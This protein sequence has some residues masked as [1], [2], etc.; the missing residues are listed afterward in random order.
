[1]N[2]TFTHCRLYNCYNTAYEF[3]PKKVVV[4]LFWNRDHAAAHVT[5]HLKVISVFRPI[6]ILPAVFH[7]E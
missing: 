5:Y 7:F 6:S 1:M 3:L 2:A 4:P